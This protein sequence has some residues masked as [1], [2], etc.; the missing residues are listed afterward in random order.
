MPVADEEAM[1]H[2]TKATAEARLRLLAKDAWWLCELGG[3]SGVE[4][5]GLQWQRTANGSTEG[6]NG[7]RSRTRTYDPLIN[8]QLLYRLS[9]AATLRPTIILGVVRRGQEGKTLQSRVRRCRGRSANSGHSP[10]PACTSERTHAAAVPP[11]CSLRE[12]VA[13]ARERMMGRVD[14]RSGWTLTAGRGP[15]ASA[16][17]MGDRRGRGRAACD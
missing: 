4:P 12:R 3:A 7:C 11:E 6:K 8:S 9:Y 5:I 17:R 13:P 10:P 1:E 16:A 2:A 15:H 14:E